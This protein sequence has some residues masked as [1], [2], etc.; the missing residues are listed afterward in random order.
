MRSAP[1]LSR[2]KIGRP[3]ADESAA[4]RDVLQVLAA[5]GEDES[6]MRA[7]VAEDGLRRCAF[8]LITPEGFP[9]CLVDAD[10]VSNLGVDAVNDAL[11]GKLCGARLWGGGFYQGHKVDVKKRSGDGQRTAMTSQ[12]VPL[13]HTSAFALP[14]PVTVEPTVG[15]V[16][17]LTAAML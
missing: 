16:A 9:S 4:V 10:A 5:E 8:A 2:E 1:V 14:P 15:E 13:L 6:G 3:L 12:S 11:R 7:E 17:S